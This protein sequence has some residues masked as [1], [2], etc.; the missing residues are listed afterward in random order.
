MIGR[1]QRRGGLRCSISWP[2]NRG[3]RGELFLELRKAAQMVKRLP[4]MQETQV[5]SLCRKTPWRRQW[6]PTPV[7]L[8]GKSHGRRS[9]VGY[10]PWGC[11]ESDRTEWLHFHFVTKTNNITLF[12][13]Q[14]P[15]QAAPKRCMFSWV[16]LIRA[17]KNERW[18]ADESTLNVSLTYWCET[19][20]PRGVNQ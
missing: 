1:C 5:R 20:S 8:P 19:A 9:L 15:W 14:F 7:L 2:K 4:T 10:S 3:G 12:N 18:K 16:L 13:L 11:K 6:H 17:E